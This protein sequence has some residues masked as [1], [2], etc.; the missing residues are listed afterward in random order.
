MRKL[1]FVALVA[2]TQ[3]GALWAQPA[4]VQP[5]VA[6]THGADR[7][8]ALVERLLRGGLVLYFRHERTELERTQDDRP[9][10]IENCA[11]QRV[12]SPAGYVSAQNI[13]EALRLLGVPIGPVLSSPL[14]RSVDTAKAAFGRAVIDARLLGGDP[15]RRRTGDDHWRDVRRVMTE[16]RA[17]RGNLVLVS[18]Y[19]HTPLQVGL[20]LAEGDAAVFGWSTDGQLVLLGTIGAQRWGD[21]VRD[22]AR[23]GRLAREAI[24]RST[25]LA[26]RAPLSQ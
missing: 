15:D 19:V 22:F 9:L 12:L 16:H 21:I 1:L 23:A 26:G 7:E 18:H 6:A 2:F 10:D 14:C 17:P 5:S 24:P 20:N 4:A 3:P 25:H 11:K 13:G 8:I